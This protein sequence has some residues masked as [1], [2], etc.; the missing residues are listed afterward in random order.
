MQT[1]IG[2]SLKYSPRRLRVTT[3][4]AV[5][6]VI[7]DF[8]FV[9]WGRYP[10]SDGRWALALAALIAYVWL[11]DGDRMSL[12][13]KIPIQ[14]WSYWGLMTLVIEC[15]LLTCLVVGLGAW[16]WTGHKVP[17]YPTSPGNLGPAFLHMCMFAPVLEEAIYRLVICVPLSARFGPKTAIAISG[18]AFGGLHV[19]YGNPSPENLV[20]GFFLAW[21][22]LKSESI[23][24]PVLLHSLGNLTALATQLGV[25][26]W[27]SSTT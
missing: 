17:L 9:L 7:A 8:V 3:A 18:L 13:I 25:W 22:Y 12:G 23:V 15:A 11:A 2:R 20:G 10:V 27:L 5:L 4:V 14:G 21:S 24:V 16:V 1:T 6:V 26:Y 19:A